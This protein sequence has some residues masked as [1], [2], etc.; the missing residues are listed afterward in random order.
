MASY[1]LEGVLAE[2]LANTPSGHWLRENVQF[3]VVP[4]MDKDGVEE[5]DQGKNRRPHDHNRDY[6]DQ[7]I[8][9]EV[10]AL[11]RLV[12]AWIADQPCFGFDL[13]CPWL[14][15][16]EHER[17]MSPSRPSDPEN[18]QRLRPFLEIFRRSSTGPLRFELSRSE[19]F[20]GWGGTPPESD[21]P[22][23]SASRWMLT[24]PHMQWAI[25]FEIPYANASGAEVNQR[26][27]RICGHDL[28][29]ALHRYLVDR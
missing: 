8:H 19:A 13:H 9:P 22:R 3:L 24:V 1:V 28:A 7:S 16:A 23:R 10:A 26:T 2:V 4:F 18:W 25:T 11:K 12:P 20:A 17:F 6:Y 27:A 14:K 21:A 29:V 5:G 15:N